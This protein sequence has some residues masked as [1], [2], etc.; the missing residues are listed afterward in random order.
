MF[1]FF[2][3]IFSFFFIT[4]TPTRT[5]YSFSFLVVSAFFHFL[6][7]RTI[8]CNIT[9]KVRRRHL[10]LL[11][12]L[13]V[14]VLFQLYNIVLTTRTISS[15]SPPPSYNNNNDGASH[16]SILKAPYQIIQIGSPRTGSTFQFQLLC[17]II[18]LKNPDAICDFLDKKKLQTEGGAMKR[19]LK[20]MK[21][22]ESFL[23]KAHEGTRGIRNLSQDGRIGVFSSGGVGSDVALYVQT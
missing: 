15:D 3:C 1:S 16:V 14:T 18:Q 7:P 13:L 17:S 20:G 23:Y 11:G 21:N 2:D 10:F 8:S 4:Y 22:K 5:Q 6:L 9:M 19:I 12:Q